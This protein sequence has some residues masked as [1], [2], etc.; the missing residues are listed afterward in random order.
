MIIKSSCLFSFKQGIA[1]KGSDS[2]VTYDTCA[3]AHARDHVIRTWKNINSRASTPAHRKLF[4]LGIYEHEHIPI[5][6]G[7]DQCISN[8]THISKTGNKPVTMPPAVMIDCISSQGLASW[9]A[10][11]RAS[12]S[13]SN[14]SIHVYIYATTP[15]CSIISRCL[16][17]PV[18][19]FS[20]DL[21]G[22]II[23]LYIGFRYIEFEIA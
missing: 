19:Q 20:L 14:S 2:F 15:F 12:T 4:F 16:F 21:E 8:H 10:S 23:Y 5:L 7:S 13:V 1:N 18:W 22:T 3:L 11:Y 9:G 6:F 17:G